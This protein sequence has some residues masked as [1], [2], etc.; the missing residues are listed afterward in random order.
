MTKIITKKA[1]EEKRARREQHA[2]VVYFFTG[3]L[4]SPLPPYGKL[5]TSSDTLTPSTIFICHQ[6]AYNPHA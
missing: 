3:V 6:K 2:K 4:L 1:W 5:A